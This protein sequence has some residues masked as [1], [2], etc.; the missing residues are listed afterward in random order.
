MERKTVLVNVDDTLSVIEA[1]SQ[2]GI[3]SYLI[4]RPWNSDYQTNPLSPHPSFYRAVLAFL[5][6]D[7]H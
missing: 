4:K 7:S 5:S 6:H 2:N 3:P 1:L